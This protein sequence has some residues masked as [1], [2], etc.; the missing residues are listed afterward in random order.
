MPPL[1]RRKNWQRS[2]PTGAKRAPGEGAGQNY[3]RRQNRLGLR[4]PLRVGGFS[5]HPTRKAV[6]A[7]RGAFG[8]HV[9]RKRSR[10]PGTGSRSGVPLKRSRQILR[11]PFLGYRSLT[12]TRLLYPARYVDL[13]A[14]DTSA[15]SS[16]A[17]PLGARR[18]AR[19]RCVRHGLCPASAPRSLLLPSWP[20]HRL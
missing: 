14:E 9:A 12:S 17:K 1:P 4:D 15:K 10:L 11:H 20:E 6:R 7:Y 18:R 2:P 16:T 13:S 5:T 19:R 8:N 3:S